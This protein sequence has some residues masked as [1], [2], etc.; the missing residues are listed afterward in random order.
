MKV[1]FSVVGKTT[2]RYLQEGI[3][4]YAKRLQHYLPFEL[5]VLPDAKAVG[6]ISPE[7]LK[8]KEGELILQQLRPDDG[9]IL[10][11]EAGKLLNS[12]QLAQTLDQWQQAPF[13]RLVFQVGGAYG[14]APTVYTRANHLL[15]LSPLTF[16]HQM[17]R[18]F[19]VEQLYRAMTILRNEPYHNP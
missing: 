13:R 11:D 16:S 19:F 10:L 3:A 17:V 15:S 14:F 1:V 9:L 18:L 6:K 5:V 8:A 4:L 12:V 2:E 7:Q